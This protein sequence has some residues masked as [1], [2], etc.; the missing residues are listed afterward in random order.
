MIDGRALSSVCYLECCATGARG[1]TANR[2]RLLHADGKFSAALVLRVNCRVLQG[3]LELVE[4][5]VVLSVVSGRTFLQ[6][7]NLHGGGGR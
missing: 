6:L 5:A 1:N 3:N 4:I 7:V 2:L